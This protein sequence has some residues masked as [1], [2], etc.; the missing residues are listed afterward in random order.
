MTDSSTQQERTD[1]G[2][3][4]RVDEFAK[5]SRYRIVHFRGEGRQPLGPEEFEPEIRHRFP[6]LDPHDPEQV[7]WADRPWEW[8]EW[9]PGE[10]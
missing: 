10:A 9:H 3:L 6:D 4:V 5:D 8:P 2:P 7:V 1:D